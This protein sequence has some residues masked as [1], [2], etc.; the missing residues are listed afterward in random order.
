MNIASFRVS[1]PPWAL[2]LCLS[3]GLTAC[4]TVNNFFLGEDNR[5]KPRD[6]QALSDPALNMRIL[7]Q[8]NIGR[9][10]EEGGLQLRPSVV[11]QTVYVV[12][13]D[14]K[15]S[16]LDVENGQEKM[17]LNLHNRVTAGVGAG[18]GQLYIGTANGD[19]KALAMDGGEQRWRAALSSHLLSRPMSSEGVVIVRTPDGIIHAFQ[20]Q[21]GSLMWRYHMPMPVLTIRGNAEPLVGGGVV[22]VTA[23]SGRFL[24]LRLDDGSVLLDQMIVLPKGRNDLERITDLDATPRM[25]GNILFASAYQDSAFALDLSTGRKLWQQDV[26]TERD[27]ALSLEQMFLVNDR[28]EIIALDQQSGKQRW[29]NQELSGRRLSSPVAIPGL[30]GVVDFEGYLHWLDDRDGRIVSRLKIGNTGSLAGG[31][32]LADRILWYLD[33]GRLVAV[34]PQ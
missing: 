18:D 2:A 9:G 11:G 10:N 25:N 1:F 34:A 21:D 22:I 20:A 28:D 31:L 3:L 4:S 29:I 6:L 14:G 30:V 12:S 8:K 27:F 7:W 15:L 23:D 19:L 13:E 32:V 26:S 5:P 33:D 24:I 16:A 17:K